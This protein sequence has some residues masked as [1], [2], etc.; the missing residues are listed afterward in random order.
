MANASAIWQQA[1]HATE[2]YKKEKKEK[3][4]NT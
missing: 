1:A 2:P 3:K 4:P